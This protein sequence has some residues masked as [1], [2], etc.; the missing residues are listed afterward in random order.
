MAA[1]FPFP[2]TSGG[3]LEGRGETQTL[4]KHGVKLLRVQIPFSPGRLVAFGL[5]VVSVVKLRLGAKRVQD[6]EHAS[7]RKKRCG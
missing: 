6:A 5:G 1:Y 4:T 3:I 2:S 7:G